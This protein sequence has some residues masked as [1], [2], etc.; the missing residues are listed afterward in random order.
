[1]MSKRFQGF[2][3]AGGGERDAR[4]GSAD[5]A[6]AHTGSST[7]SIV[8]DVRTREEF[9]ASHVPNA[10]NIPV[11]ELAARHAE[12]GPKTT[13]IVIYCRSGA[14]SSTAANLLTRLGFSKITDIGAMS[15]WRA[16]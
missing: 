15:N 12:L 3:S 10:M 6:D 11:Q 5:T 9:A 16:R 1:M 14:R 8:L 7:D 2:S 4:P 13:P